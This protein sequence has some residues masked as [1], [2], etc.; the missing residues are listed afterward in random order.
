VEDIKSILPA[1]VNEAEEIYTDI[2]ITDQLAKTTFQKFFQ[3]GTKK[4]EGFSELMSSSTVKKLKPVVNELRAIKSD[5]E[6]ANMRIAGQASGRAM[7]E[8]MRR[9]FTG[10]KDLAAFLDYDFKMRGC[11]YSAY[12]PVVA[13]GDVSHSSCGMALLLI[14]DRM[15]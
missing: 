15:L 5:G 1:I 9:K 11:D 13:G 10:E 14:L 12:V 8:A 4:A 6:I 7:T 2:P 3:R